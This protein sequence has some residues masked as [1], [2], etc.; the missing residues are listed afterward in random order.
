[1]IVIDPRE[2]QS[3]DAAVNG[4]WNIAIKLNKAIIQESPDDLAAHLRLGFAYLQSNKLRLAKKEFQNVL[5][6][7]PKNNIAEEH[8]EK[9][10]ILTSKKKKRHENNA[11][12]DPDLFIEIPGKTRTVRL[13]NLGRKEDLAGV[14]IGE[15]LLLKVKR[16]RLEVRT[17]QDEYIGNLPDDISKRMSYFMS[18]NST[19]STHVKEINLSDV[20]VF[21]RELTKGKKVG[22]Y[23]SFPSN[24][25]VMLSDIQH[26]DN[27]DSSSSSIDE[28]IEEDDRDGGLDDD[29]WEKYEQEK[30]LK[31]LIQIEEDDE[32]E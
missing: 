7:Q 28:D 5:K 16:R 15:Q 19:Y 6:L 3:I 21:I 12:Y 14:S 27:L 4:N 25:H 2:Q 13:V 32:E 11:Q 18:D 30:D 22:Q 29:A 10:D 17:T 26:L 8:L 31:G 20:V 1:M 23:P 24:P 9:I